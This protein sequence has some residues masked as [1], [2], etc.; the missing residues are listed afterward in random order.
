M[1]RAF[2]G[3]PLATGT[4]E[5]LLKAANRAP[6]AG[7]SQGYSFLVLEGQEQSAPLWTIL[8]EATAS[9]DATED[10]RTQPR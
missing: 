5:R 7:F 1:I 6:S 2:T 8:Y 10:A 3:E 9:E 4:T